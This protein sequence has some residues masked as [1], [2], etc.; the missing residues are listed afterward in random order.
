LKAKNK[1]IKEEIIEVLDEKERKVKFINTYVGDLG[2]YVRGKVYTLTAE[3][4]KV[5]ENDVEEIKG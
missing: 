1:I 2:Y 3:E 5:F 4:Y